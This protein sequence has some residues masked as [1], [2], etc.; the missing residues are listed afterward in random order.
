MD[1]IVFLNVYGEIKL[2]GEKVLQK[3]CVKYIIFCISWVYVGKGNNFV[4]IMLCLVKE[5]EELVV[6]ND[7]FG[8]LI[9][10]ELLVDCIVYVICVVVDKLEVVGLYYLVVGGIIIWYDYV[11]LV[12]EEVCK[13]GINFVF[14]KF[15]VVLIMVYFILVCRFYNFRFN[16]EK[17]QQNFAFVL[18]DWQV[19]VK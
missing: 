10:V 16:I 3:Y 15:N 7:Q 8:V 13:V 4:K 1:V 5:C 2:V 18:F 11:V 6:I 17:F 19:G 14:N 9:G 12:F